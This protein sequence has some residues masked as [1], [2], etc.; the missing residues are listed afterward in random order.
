MLSFLKEE[1]SGH[2][3]KNNGRITEKVL[4]PVHFNLNYPAN[5]ASFTILYKELYTV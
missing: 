1:S 4:L 2:S 3:T 5:M